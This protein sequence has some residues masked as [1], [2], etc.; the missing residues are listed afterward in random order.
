MRPSLISVWVELRPNPRAGQRFHHLRNGWET[1]QNCKVRI[2][3]KSNE[4]IV[5][6]VQSNRHHL[7]N[8]DQRPQKAH[9]HRYQRRK[10][11]E[12]IRTSDWDSEAES[13]RA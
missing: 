4:Q 5:E 11:R 7:K 13:D 6:A 10:I 9:K 1:T 12:F 3:P 8:V 2:M